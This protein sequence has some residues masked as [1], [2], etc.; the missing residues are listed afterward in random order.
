MTFFLAGFSAHQ[1]EVVLRI[2]D[3]LLSDD[4]KILFRVAM[5]L[6]KNNEHQLLAIGNEYGELVTRLRT[7]HMDVCGLTHTCLTTQLVVSR[8]FMYLTH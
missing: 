8:L 2:I 1:F 5:L 6:L 4:I 3:I 7:L